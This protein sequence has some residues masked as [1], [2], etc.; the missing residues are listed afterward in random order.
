MLATRWPEVISV[1]FVVALASGSARA[2]RR[3]CPPGSRPSL[4]GCVEIGARAKLRQTPE[5]R[6]PSTEPRMRVPELS[7]EAFRD[8]AYGLN[9]RNRALLVLELTRLEK[10]LRVTPAKSPD[11]PQLVR[12]LAEG[13]AELA[14]DA[15]RDRLRAELEVE[16]AEREERS[17]K[18][19]AVPK[20][21]P[22][23]TRL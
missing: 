18:S 6:R 21:S 3:S 13:Y 15:E 4:A 9:K 5:A 19:Q 11:R 20:K 1:M 14:A 8:P 23:P 10:L 17:S 22:Y 12:R 2:E 7:P 16:R